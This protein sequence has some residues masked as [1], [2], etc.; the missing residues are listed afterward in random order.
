MMERSVKAGSAC[1][2]RRRQERTSRPRPCAD[3]RPRPRFSTT[4]PDGSRPF[5]ARIPIPK[6]P[7]DRGNG[8]D[9][10][11]EPRFCESERSLTPRAPQ[12][13]RWQA[14]IWNSCRISGSGAGS[15]NRTRTKSLEGSCD[16]IS[17]CPLVGVCIF[18]RGCG[19]NPENARDP[20]R[21]SMNEIDHD[22]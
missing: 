12:A 8:S 2:R 10:I 16:T 22:E 7:G 13:C 6:P 1:R 5:R 18:H 15:G 4:V 21:P 11:R 20:D 17:P 14:T 9:R 19:G 3:A